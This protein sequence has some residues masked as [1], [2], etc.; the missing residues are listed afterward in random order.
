MDGYYQ[1]QSLN[2]YFRGPVRQRGSG[3]GSLALRA[4]RVAIPFVS[5]YVIPSAKRVG[6]EFIKQLV[7][8]AL[9]IVSGKSTVKK[10]VKRAATNTAKKQL[11]GGT[12]RKRKIENTNSIS[13]RSKPRSSRSSKKRSKI[14]IFQNLPQRNGNS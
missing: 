9:E 10:A 12:T 7:P 6:K 1:Q 5:K 11:G 8:E 2:N 4:V 13:T 3:L 14:D